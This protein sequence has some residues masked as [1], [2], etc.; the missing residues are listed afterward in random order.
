MSELETVGD[1]EVECSWCER[2]LSSKARFQPSTG[3]CSTCWNRIAKVAYAVL[4]MRKVWG[5]S[6]VT[7]AAWSERFFGHGI[8]ERIAFHQ[9][10]IRGEA[11]AEMWIT[12]DSAMRK[13]ER[14]KRLLRALGV[15]MREVHVK[16]PN[17]HAWGG[18]A[19]AL[20]LGELAETWALEVLGPPCELEDRE[21]ALEEEAEIDY[22]ERLAR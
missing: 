14:L 19:V 16:C 20:V 13:W 1:R 2:S 9:V 8:Q 7:G 10:R 15:P 22:L 17:D 12:P 18:A 4:A 21:G 5:R 6:P 11:E 3:L